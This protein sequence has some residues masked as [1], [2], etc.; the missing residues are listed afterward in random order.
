MLE[1]TVGRCRFGIELLAVGLSLFD[2]LEDVD[3]LLDAGE[4]RPVESLD[5]KGLC[6][7]YEVLRT[8]AVRILDTG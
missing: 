4:Q 8:Q 1:A 6:S 3:L 7:L 5:D 2:F